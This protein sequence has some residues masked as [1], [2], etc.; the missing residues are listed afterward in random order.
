LWIKSRRRIL[1]AVFP[2]RNFKLAF[3]ESKLPRT[4]R[5]LFRHNL[6]GASTNA[7]LTCRRLTSCKTTTAAR[8]L[9]KTADPKKY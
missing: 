8:Q 9:A 7:G 4:S 2:T 6:G 1:L 5:G 3:D